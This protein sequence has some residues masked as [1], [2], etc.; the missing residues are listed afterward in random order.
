MSE[1]QSKILTI[2]IALLMTGCGVEVQEQ[3]AANAGRQT[4]AT[5]ENPNRGKQLARNIAVDSQAESITSES[6]RAFLEIMEF[7]SSEL[8]QQYRSS[9][10]PLFQ[11][12]SRD[13][14]GVDVVNPIDS[15]HPLNRLYHSGFMCGGVAIGDLDGDELPD[16]YF[17]RGPLPNR[18]YRQTG[19]FEFEDITARAGV[20]S[21]DRWSAGCTLV[22]IDGDNDLDIYVCN[23][24]SA[25]Q[26]YLNDGTGKF[27]E[28]AA[29]WN[30]NHA[31][32]SLTSSFCDFDND[33][34]LDCYLLTNRLYRAG[35]LPAA[36]SVLDRSQGRLAIREEYQPY[37]KIKGQYSQGTGLTTFG[38]PDLLLRNDGESFTNVTEDSGISGDGYGLSV[39]WWDFDGDGWLDIYVANDF[40]DPDRLYRNQG[41]GTFAEVSKQ[42]LPHTTWF[43]MGSDV[44]DLNGDGLLDMLVVDMSATNHYKQK[45]T[46]GAMNAAEIAA[47]SG[48]P[49][50]IMRNALFLNSGMGRF[51][52]AAYLANLADSDWS[53]AVKLADFD[54]NGRVDVFISNGMSRNFNDSDFKVPMAERVGRSEWEV[55]EDRPA[56]PER[57][58]AFRNHGDLQFEDVS[59]EWGLDHYGMSF[60]AAHGDL[61]RDGDLDLV[62]VNLDEPVLIYRNL[63]VESQ[64]NPN[65]I[66]V[67]LRGSGKNRWAIGA[68][69]QVE[70]VTG[71]N[72]AHFNPFSG[73]LSSNEP[74]IHFGLG[75]EERI[76]R[77]V[78]T[79]PHGQQQVYRDLPS[80]RI[81]R[82]AQSSAPT[83]LESRQ[84]VQE[85]PRLFREL[86][87]RANLRHY[88]KDFDDFELQPL[89]PNKLSM[90]GPGMACG[91]IDG[92]GDE[93]LYLGGGAMYTGAILECDK[94][95]LLSPASDSLFNEIGKDFLSEDMGCLL[96]DV[97]SD[98]DLDL[99]VV[100]GGVEHGKEVG[101][102]RDRLYFN[103]SKG[104]FSRAP[105]DA[106]PE[107]LESGS[108][109]AAADFDADGDL[110][111]FVGNRV[112]PGRYPLAGP[113]RLLRNEGGE[114]TDV[115][116]DVAPDLLDAGMVTGAVWSDANGDGAID[117][118]LSSE[119]GPIQLYSNEGGRLV[120]NTVQSGLADYTG[121]WNG[122][123]AGDFDN[124]GDTDYVAT[125]FGENTK[126][127]ASSSK[128]VLL[129]YGDFE[130]N[131]TMHLVEAEF[132]GDHLFPI[133][134]KSCSTNAIP[135][136]AMKFDSYH[137][138]A[139]AT[140]EE[141]YTADC[142]AD[143]LKL[144]AT[145]LKSS[146]LI[147]D[148]SGRFS[149]KA[150]PRI[151]QI[152]PGF[153]I[154]VLDANLDSHLDI[155]LA[156]NFFGPQ[157]ETG[158]M[159]GG[160]G[161]LLLGNGK[162]E[163]TPMWPQES[164]L[165]TPGDARSVVLS[166]LT[167][168]QLPELLVASNDG[169]LQVFTLGEHAQTE[170]TSIRL[171]GPVGNRPGVGASVAIN[172]ADGQSQKHE[173]YAGAG[174]LSQ[175]SSRIVV[176]HRNGAQLTDIHVTWPDG[177]ESRYPVESTEND[178]RI[179][180]SK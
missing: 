119:W 30:L 38:Q 122:I 129:Y 51:M 85:S 102:L 75:E 153:G 92:D 36:N 131:G 94:D 166:D 162:N 156:Q 135:G 27:Q 12:L 62:V 37:Y 47:V 26:L 17:T 147:N 163:F 97:D 39:M 149:V 100:S 55:Y 69:L 1:L 76:S 98:D 88:E 160:V 95:Q 87:I 61:D 33:G 86:T 130:S 82:I 81:Y 35:G 112:I 48:P 80:N 79:W 25:N 158:P 19:K 53:W 115:T 58:L 174:Y 63:A 104:N 136:L 121:W 96:L 132:E 32:S 68:T 5:Q 150:L 168:D 140:L 83:E 84:G 9:D 178:I 90:F 106:L 74:A 44:A 73:Y 113:S 118:L 6:D 34:D 124:D 40:N 16:L 13:S 11:L 72:V 110:D 138:F 172:Y 143:S 148:G 176:G 173:I 103:D 43:S 66:R 71:S 3:E 161:L 111:V 141:I 93:D 31:G 157:P 108:V 145:T 101:R 14:T 146:V 56:R 134:G 91:D 107:N 70:T 2:G 54:L 45:T 46:M 52:E 15:S 127:H 105:H 59:E 123:A 77:L 164:G 180:R 179:D 24:D 139:S 78:I 64:E 29:K 42:V 23:Y 8:P 159:D 10:A 7:E 133:R 18:L 175:S 116:D 177:T 41:N 117:L 170:Y 21:E 50:Q 126:Y 114:F 99:F 28:V 142:L 65:R 137:Q 171:K 167:G 154:A 152:A 4:V 57:N 128:P 165:V 22:D 109:L 89:L 125:N 151:A 120:E 67:E 144:S 155:Y 49:P 60:S 20:A 169:P